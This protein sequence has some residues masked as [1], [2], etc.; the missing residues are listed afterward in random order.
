MCLQQQQQLLLHRH[1]QLQSASRAMATL[2]AAVAVVAA[3][4]ATEA[5]VQLAVLHLLPQMLTTATCNTLMQIQQMHQNL[6]QNQSFCN[7]DLVC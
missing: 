2:T 3:E 4:T 1:Q 5:G 6:R 7:R